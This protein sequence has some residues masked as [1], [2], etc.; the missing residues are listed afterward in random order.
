MFACEHAWH[1]KWQL[2]PRALCPQR[3]LAVGF[4]LPP[5]RAGPPRK[6]HP[7]GYG[8]D[9]LLELVRFRLGNRKDANLFGG[10]PYHVGGWGEGGLNMGLFG[11][12]PPPSPHHLV[13]RQSR[14]DVDFNWGPLVDIMALGEVVPS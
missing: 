8:Y 2:Q 12:L 5:K 3:E 7:N 11:H 13:L 4:V 1:W 14:M 6:T 10:F 9:F